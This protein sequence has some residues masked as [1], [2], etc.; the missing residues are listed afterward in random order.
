MKC[1][2]HENNF[3]CRDDVAAWRSALD[4]TGRD[5]IFEL[6]W[7]LDISAISTWTQHADG[8]R[9]NTDVECYCDTLV[10]WDASVV[11]RFYELPPWIQ[12][13][14]PGRWNDLDTLNVGNGTIDGITDVERQT[15]AT[16]WAITCSPL[17]IGDD[18]DTLDDYGYSLLTNA[19]VI[20]IN[21]E[22]LSAKPVQPDVD[23]QVWWSRRLA[24]NN[25]SYTVAL[26]NLG[27]DEATVAAFWVDF[28]FTGSALVYDVWAGMDVATATG[29]WAT[30]VPR[31]GSRLLRVTPL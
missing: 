18:L 11:Q 5:F 23:Q 14:G 30:R 8:W 3:F 7:S 10:R 31:H 22:G 12:Y 20:A 29:G 2:R 9:I 4:K 27:E 28:G 13:S 6:S 15:Y 25:D 17:Y 24:P 1:K 16:L 26:F 19:E 21:Q